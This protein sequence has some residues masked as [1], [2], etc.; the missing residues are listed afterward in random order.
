MP[1]W[2]I[3]ALLAT[4]LVVLA[5]AVVLALIVGDSRVYLGVHWPTDVIG[6]M[7]MGAMWFAVVAYAFRPLAERNP[8][9]VDRRSTIEPL[10][11]RA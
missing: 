8:K 5:V 3:D 2:A 11:S 10:S 1:V 6:G 9:N 7:L 4:L